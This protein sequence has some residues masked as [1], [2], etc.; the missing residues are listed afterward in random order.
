MKFINNRTEAIKVKKEGNE[1]LPPG[2]RTVKPGATIEAESDNYIAG[3]LKAGLTAVKKVKGPKDKPKD[4]K[5][6][7]KPKE[8]P[9]AEGKT[10][11][12]AP[13][14]KTDKSSKKEE[15]K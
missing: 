3:Y 14:P 1:K 7:E 9:K 5:P 15:K 6:K 8:E 4:E 13:T 2:F 11:T 12:V 10:E